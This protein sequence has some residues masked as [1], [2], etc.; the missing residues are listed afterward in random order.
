[1][2]VDAGSVLGPDYENMTRMSSGGMGELFR[3]HKR[4]LDVEVVVKRVKAQFHGRINETREADILK[5]LRHQYL[6]R[7]YDIIYAPDG[8]IYTVMDY[9]PGC[10]LQEYV[11]RHGALSQ[12]QSLKWLKQLCEVVSYLHQQKPPVIHC[13]IKPQNIMITPDGDICLIDFN[14]SLIF[15]SPEMNALGATH[16]YA[17][18]E[19]YH[20]SPEVL[21]RIPAEAGIRWKAWSS[22]A[23][24]YGRISE[25]TDIYGIGATGYF[26]LTGYA[27]AHSLE[28]VIPLSRY[29][30][31]ITDAL[32]EV[33]E[34]AMRPKQKERFPSVR[35]M[36]TALENLKKADRRY[37]NWKIRCQVTAVVL[38]TLMLLSVFSIWLGVELQNREREDQ[39]AQLITEADELIGQQRYEDSL[40]VLGSAV[41]LEENR[42]EAYSRIGTVLYR[43][44][45]YEEC[46]DLLAGLTF[47]YDEKAMARQDFDYVQAELSYVLGS[48]YFQEE[49]YTEAVQNLELAVW[50]APEEPVYFRDLIIAQAMRGNM[51]EA[52]RQYQDLKKMENVEE[53]DL[54]LVEGELA[55]ADGRYEEA[56]VPLLELA[57][58]N[59]SALAGRS[60]LL[61]AQCCR[62]LGDISREISVLEEA[63]AV[64]D[65]SSSVMH[66]E[67]LAEAY[68]QSGAGNG[69]PEQYEKAYALCSGL[70]ERGVTDIS[71]QLNAALA[72][73]YLGRTEE[74]LQEIESAV[75]EYPNDYRVY[76]RAALLYLD[77]QVNDQEKAISAYEQA[78]TLYK[79][80]G[81]QDSEMTYLTSLI[82]ELSSAYG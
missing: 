13:D 24:A 6:P 45:R 40:D 55:Y 44:G 20:V 48:C 61:A 80:A 4:G 56:L 72:L 63:C 26:M 19:Q 66:T 52:V 67:L 35:A 58:G 75:K 62:Y 17:A 51:T 32:L 43:L 31:K 41:S 69:S 81:V 34:R 82:Q 59:D 79:G 68:L 15:E 7:I 71:V 28:S 74:A 49:E 47:A 39:Y 65:A 12:K 60:Y 22:Q 70:M 14:T 33:L 23:A 25:R 5:N 18:P 76:V 64:L 2:Q 8:F 11:K 37:R 10:S 36:L 3:A 73:Q 9:I 1:M 57:R 77:P 42:I 16:G 38:G 29:N 46:I 54:L 30:I 21:R 50:F 27:P 53:E 78:E